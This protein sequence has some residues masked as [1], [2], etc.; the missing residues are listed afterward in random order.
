MAKT[1]LIATGAVW[2]V[3]M[4]VTQCYLPPMSCAKTAEQIEMLLEAWSKKPVLGGGPDPDPT[5]GMGICVCG[6]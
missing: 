4:P 1:R 2:S 6:G 3:C 5:R